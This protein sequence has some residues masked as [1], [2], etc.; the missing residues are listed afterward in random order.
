MPTPNDCDMPCTGNSSQACGGPNRLT[1]YANDIYPVTNP[2]ANGFV[3]LG[4]WADN[5]NNR[6]LPYEVQVPGGCKNM[7]VAACTSVCRGFGFSLAGVEY[8][9]GKYRVS[10]HVLAPIP[11]QL[12]TPSP[13]R[14]L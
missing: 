4:C 14:R 12:P 8:S 7:S 9:G 6:T 2:G 10:R 1:V 5:V 3:S 11:F 13:P